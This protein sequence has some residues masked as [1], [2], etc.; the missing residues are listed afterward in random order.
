MVK[1]HS[2]SVLKML[3]SLLGVKL[4][5]Y[6]GLLRQAVMD[7]KR[8]CTGFLLLIWVSLLS[9]LSPEQQELLLI[10]IGCHGES[11][12]NRKVRSG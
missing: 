11:W 8:F 4:R 1:G 12:R 7:F 10:S 5:V 6:R 2:Q 3:E 9:F